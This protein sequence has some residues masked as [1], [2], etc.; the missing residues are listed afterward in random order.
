ML[1]R[2]LQGKT[3]AFARDPSAPDGVLRALVAFA[4]TAGGILRSGHA[5]LS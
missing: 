4:N 5:E 1:S 3:L 2:A